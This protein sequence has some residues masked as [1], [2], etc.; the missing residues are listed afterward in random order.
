MAKEHQDFEFTNV[1]GYR[2]AD[3]R[4]RHPV[5]GLP[6]YSYFYGIGFGAPGTYPYT[7][8]GWD[9]SPNETSQN[10]YGE[11]DYSGIGNASDGSGVGTGTAD[12]A[13]PV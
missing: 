1:D 5:S 9:K 2:T 13:G 10:N 11:G 4:S 3:R 7:G 12:G 8:Y 6:W